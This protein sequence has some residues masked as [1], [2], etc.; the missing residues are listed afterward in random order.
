MPRVRP[1]RKTAR[2][3]LPANR[4]KGGKVWVPPCLIISSLV[5]C[6]IVLAEQASESRAVVFIKPEVCF[7]FHCVIL[8][9]CYDY[10]AL[11]GNEHI[12]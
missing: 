6:F 4:C 2:V 5:I 1:A 12:K 8:A 7:Q 3:N 11:V 9:I 10:R